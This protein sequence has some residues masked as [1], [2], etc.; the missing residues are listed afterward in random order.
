MV[1]EE[2]EDVSEAKAGEIVALFGVDC[3]SRTLSPAA[4]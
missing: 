1:S 4:M 3:K 2:M